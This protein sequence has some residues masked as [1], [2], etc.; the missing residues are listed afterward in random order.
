MDGEPFVRD[1]HV[2][3]VLEHSDGLIVVCIDIAGF[4]VDGPAVRFGHL[5][6]HVAVV[7]LQQPGFRVDGGTCGDGHRIIELGLVQIEF[8][9]FRVDGGSGGVCDLRHQVGV[10]AANAHGLVIDFLGLQFHVIERL[11]G[12]IGDLDF[13]VDALGGGIAQILDALT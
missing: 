3:Q 13:Q 8:A 7:P 10:V 12:I 5:G 2:V 6:Q 1:L 9:G 11:A 4:R